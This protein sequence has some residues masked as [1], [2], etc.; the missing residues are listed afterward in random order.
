MVNG[1]LASS[2]SFSDHDVAHL[3]LA[4]MQWYPDIM[5][6][7][8]GIEQESPAYV[9]TLTDLGALLLPFNSFNIK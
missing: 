4:P 7:I 9:S 6:W 1:M 3:M 8:F 5:G 2:Y